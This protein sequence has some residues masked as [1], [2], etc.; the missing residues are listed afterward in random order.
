MTL[1]EELFKVKDITKIKIIN[2]VLQ[3]V[4]NNWWTKAKRVA[5]PRRSP[6]TTFFDQKLNETKAY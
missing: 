3:N 5:C 6:V 1:R 4:K 2:S